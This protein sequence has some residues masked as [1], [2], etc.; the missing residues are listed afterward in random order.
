MAGPHP[1]VSMAS[2]LGQTIRRRRGELQ[3]SQAN[4]ASQAGISRRVW[5]DLELGKIQGSEATLAK[6]ESVLQVPLTVLKVKKPVDDLTP[7]R[8][9]LIAMIKVMKLAEL[10]QALLIVLRIRCQSAED[11][12]HRYE[13]E[14]MKPAVCP[15]C[16]QPVVLS[17]P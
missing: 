1:E 9:E 16:G 7:L 5:G 2:P 3:L 6:I 15:H 17:L 4:A 11:L 12:L 13:Q 8:N 14:F 10:K